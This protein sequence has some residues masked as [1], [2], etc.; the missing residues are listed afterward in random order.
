[1]KR[2]RPQLQRGTCLFDLHTWAGGKPPLSV[3]YFVNRH[4][5]PVVTDPSDLGEFRTVLFSLHTARDA[6]KVARLAHHKAPGQEWIAGGGAAVNPT[7][8]SWLMDYVLV[9]DGFEA[10]PLLLQGER[11]LEGL[12]DCQARDP[13]RYRDEGIFPEPYAPRNLL[14]TVGCRHRCAFCIS[15]WRRQYREQSPAVVQRFIADAPCSQ[16]GL[17]TTSAVDVSYHA[18]LLEWLREHGRINNSMS[19]T[20]RGVSE[21]ALTGWKGNILFGLEGMREEV[22]G[23]VNKPIPESLALE[24]VLL[25]LRHGWKV[26]LTYQF[27]LPGDRPSGVEN[28]R[29]LVEKVRRELR[30][31]QLEVSFIPHQPSPFTPMQWERPRWDEETRRAILDMRKSYFGSGKTGVS[32]FVPTP[33]G[34]PRWVTQIVSERIPV[35]PGV[36]KAMDAIP[37]TA[38]FEKAVDVLESHGVDAA[39]WFRR[40]STNEALPWEYVEVHTSRERLLAEFNKLRRRVQRRERQRPTAGESDAA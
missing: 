14:L 11:E 12:F 4:S 34:A 25:A 5:L 39:R 7:P 3:Q 28:V 24:K 35:T 6:L 16:L 1:M 15:P 27:N 22:R 26:R 32:V 9:G 10:F 40:Q 2:S 20:V 21:G 30:K 18:D 37:A 13:V 8:V 17:T 19:N 36:V 31:G 29:S 23:F 33:L 38:S